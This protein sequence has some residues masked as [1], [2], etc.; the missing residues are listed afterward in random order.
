V[1]QLRPGRSWRHNP[2]YASELSR[3]SE[4]GVRAFAGGPILDVLGVEVDGV[5][6]AAGVGEAPLCEMIDELV[7]AALHL[8]RGAPA[9]QARVGPG[10]VQLVLEAR[11]E[12]VL[13]SLLSLRAPAKMLASG[14]LADAGRLRAAALGAAQRVLADLLDVAPALRGAPWVRRLTRDLGALA[15]VRA[16]SAKPWPLESRATPGFVS[17]SGRG[18]VRVEVR[19]PAAAA[20]RLATRAQV[21]HAPLAPLLGP[22]S[23]ALRFGAA[24]RGPSLSLDAPPFLALRELVRAAESLVQAFE[25]GEPAFLLRWG[26]LEL[27]CDLTR[28]ELRAEGLRE[29]VRVRPLELA[30][31][32]AAAARAFARRALGTGPQSKRAAAS[33]E[34]LESLESAAAALL[35]HCRDLESGDLHRA[36][37]AVRAPPLPAPHAPHTEAATEPL[38]GKLR[39]LVHRLAF[40]IPVGPLDESG[41]HLFAA[42]NAAVLQTASGLVAID[43]GSSARLWHLSGVAAA[44]DALARASGGE[45]YALHE[46]AL[47][48]IDPASG[49]TRFRRVIRGAGARIFAVP[50]GCAVS[51]SA[52]GLAMVRDDGAL[53]FRARLTD[54]PVAL[55]LGEKVLVAQLPGGQLAALD[56]RDGSE[57]WRRRVG[58]RASA[59]RLALAHSEGSRRRVVVATEDARGAQRLLALDLATGETLWERP[60][61]PFPEANKPK[62]P[63]PSNAAA[64]LDGTAAADEAG[65]RAADAA[66][67]AEAG[68]PEIAPILSARSATG[69]V[70]ALHDA[71]IAGEL[72]AVLFDRG[73]VAC[74]LDDGAQVAARELPWGTSGRLQP[75][76]VAHRRG[77]GDAPGALAAPALLALAPGGAA[78][79]LDARANP[80]WTRPA[81]T[82]ALAPPLAAAQLGP[83]LL[84]ASDAAELLDA[85]SGRTLARPAMADVDAAALLSDSSV[86][87]HL[88]DGTLALMRL[89]AHFSL[90]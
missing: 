32:C 47:V 69:P 87:V 48:R 88:R 49:E 35:L 85:D 28:D 44:P 70:R 4:A 79:L 24:S 20:A 39:R 52:G 56:A 15:K 51:L 19:V 67:T 53:S 16:I 61:A 82:P 33:D 78:Q 12:D 59:A 57:L 41:L 42:A 9:A 29:P 37:A 60:L 40:E 2:S 50:G 73:L 30:S 90:A 27:Q 86:L 71:V 22:G 1:F 14:L 72:C 74:R 55:L 7:Q 77:P 5:D 3:L 6:I 26:A 89:Q 13:L 68:A 45:L 54:E 25:S 81:L 84:L 64:S 83:V 75:I 76:D 62:T 66:A 34:P 80:L 65:A 10:P 46:A 17:R 23:L 58:V 43:L 38:R 31:A 18:P 21:P 8:A 36:P 11:G 63:P